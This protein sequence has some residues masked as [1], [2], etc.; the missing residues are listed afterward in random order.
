MREK[1]SLT[2]E[3]ADEL[4]EALSEERAA[5]ESPAGIPV[6]ATGQ[7]DESDQKA[8]REGSG[9]GGAGPRTED[10]GG[11]GSKERREDRQDRRERRWQKRYFGG[12]VDPEWVDN[13]MDKVTSGIGKAIEWIDSEAVH[14]AGGCDD[15]S[16]TG[17]ARR[18]NWGNSQTLSSMEQ[19]EGEDYQFGDNRAAYSKLR[20]LRLT[21]SRMNGNTFSA[22]TVIDVE[23]ADSVMEDGCLIGASLH[24]LRMA[25]SE[26]TEVRVTGSKL[27]RVEMRGKSKI[28][29][30][31]ISGCNVTALTLTD[32]S[33]IEKSRFSG[34]NATNV[35]LSA[36]SAVRKARVNGSNANRV[37]LESSSVSD[38]ET[39]VSNLTDVQVIGSQIQDT[40]FRSTQI[41]DSRFTDCKLASVVFAD[42]RMERSVFKDVEFRREPQGY[43]GEA[44]NLTIVDVSLESCGFINCAFRNTTIKGIT[45]KNLRFT[46]KDFSGITIKNVK[47]L[48]ALAD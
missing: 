33:G 47:D 24:E 40:S 1:G 37:S 25:E 35:T 16:G 46:G 45:A 27:T 21:R 43:S 4:L 10:S 9:E 29:D 44:R 3:Q 2:K 5:R 34:S 13:V 28:K 6:D 39:S 15:G 48:E 32:D 12:F 23:M 42:S 19:P 41:K 18:G 26:I 20:S 8:E 31:R 22:S 36:K 11:N 30:L 14:F 38:T 17:N 7:G